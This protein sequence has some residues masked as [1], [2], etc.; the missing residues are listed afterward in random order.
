MF[1]LLSYLPDARLQLRIRVFPQFHEPAVVVA[2]AA[3]VAPLL[4]QLAEAPIGRSQRRALLERSEIA[5]RGDGA[6][7]HGYGRVAL[8]RPLV[9]AG[10]QVQPA[11][12]AAILVVPGPIALDRVLDSPLRERDLG[13]GAVAER[14]AAPDGFGDRGFVLGKEL[15][16]TVRPA[17]V[18]VQ[19]PESDVGPVRGGNGREGG[20]AQRRFPLAGRGIGRAAG[21]PRV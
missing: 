11:Y 5:R 18:R 9:G 13:R 17:H 10:Q 16:G 3:R 14:L 2:R 12:R 20:P 15:P 7:V 4:V 1:Q 8:A 21:M 19:P 6:L